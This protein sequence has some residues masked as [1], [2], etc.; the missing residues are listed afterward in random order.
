MRQ[1]ILAIL[2]L[3]L[4]SQIGVSAQDQ[5]KHGENRSLVFY[6]QP[7]KSIFSKGEIIEFNFTL[8][9]DGGPVFIVGKR[10]E[11]SQ[12]VNLEILDRAGKTVD[13]CGRIVGQIESAESFRTL[14]AGQSVH[15]KLAIS[16][17]NKGDRGRAWGYNFDATGKYVIKAAY[18]NPQPQEYLKKLFPDAVVPRGPILAAAITIE[19]R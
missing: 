2:A 18:S 17:V 7:V 11:L 3:I 16:C 12:N 13:W 4:L 15:G 14:E 10:F 19:V 8:R 6:A 1:H 5:F 9:N